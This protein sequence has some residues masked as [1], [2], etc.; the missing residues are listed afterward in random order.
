MQRYPALFSESL[1]RIQ[2]P[3]NFLVLYLRFSLCGSDSSPQVSVRRV[4]T[5]KSVPEGAA[6]VRLKEIIQERRELCTPGSK[7]AGASPFRLHASPFPSKRHGM[8]SYSILVSSWHMIPYHR[9]PSFYKGS[10][11]KLVQILTRRQTRGQTHLMAQGY[12]SLA[13]KAACSD[14]IPENPGRDKLCYKVLGD[15]I[16]KSSSN[17][18]V[19]EKKSNWHVL[20]QLP[21]LPVSV[22][23]PNR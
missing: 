15:T 18:S 6:K 7:A 10:S 11:G 2:P 19:S 1:R 17:N 22:P 8:R 9:D 21:V 16:L 12:I 20:S 23:F 14:N 13:L 5:Q 3:W 4:P